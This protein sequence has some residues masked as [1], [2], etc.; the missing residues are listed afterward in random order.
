MLTETLLKIPFSVIG[1]FFLVQT[2][3]WLQGKC[4]RI[5]LSHAFMKAVKASLQLKPPVLKREQPAFQNM[6]FLHFPI[7]GHFCRIRIPS[8]NPDPDPASQN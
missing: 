8:A 7:V 1:R 4:A 3:H 5:N 2:S 6:T